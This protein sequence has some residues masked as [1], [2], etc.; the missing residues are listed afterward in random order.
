MTN[1]TKANLIA[2][3]NAGLGLAIAFGVNLTDLQTAAVLVFANSVASVFVGVTFKNS[4]KR[5]PEGTGLVS[6]VDGK[7]E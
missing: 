1:A 5:V 6:V 7:V 3:L 2:A 4:P